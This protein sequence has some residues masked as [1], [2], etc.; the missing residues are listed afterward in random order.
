MAGDTANPTVNQVMLDASGVPLKLALARAERTKR[1][2]AFMLAFPLLIFILVSFIYPIT[3]ML[4]R[5]V[6][7]PA[8][9]SNMPNF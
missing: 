9:N 1:R 7:N 4:F 6:D 3:M 5:S 2:K 8:I